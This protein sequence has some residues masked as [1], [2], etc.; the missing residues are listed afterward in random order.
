MWYLITNCSVC[1][2]KLWFNSLCIILYNE[3]GTQAADI[4]T[5]DTLRRGLGSARSGWQCG[6]VVTRWPRST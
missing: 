1:D 6:L 5:F 3:V 4:G 2:V